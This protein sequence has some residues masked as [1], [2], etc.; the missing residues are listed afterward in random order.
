MNT[1]LGDTRSDIVRALAIMPAALFLS[2]SD[3][4]ARYKRSMLGPFWLTLVR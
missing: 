3:T 4:K 1:R 2:W